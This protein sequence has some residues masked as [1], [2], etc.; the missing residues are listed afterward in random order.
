MIDKV[1]KDRLSEAKLLNHNI[2]EK[3][4]GNILIITLALLLTN[5]LDLI[6][7]EMLLVRYHQLYR[8]LQENLSIR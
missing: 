1:I 3:K 8:T 6:F 5:T 2:E 7:K 4:S